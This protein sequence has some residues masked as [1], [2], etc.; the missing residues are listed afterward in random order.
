MPR[1]DLG[2]DW[3]TREMGPLPENDACG[4]IEQRGNFFKVPHLC[5]PSLMD[6]FPETCVPEIVMLVSSEDTPWE[7]EGNLSALRL[8]V[9]GKTSAK[10][11][12]AELKVRN[13][14][15]TAIAQ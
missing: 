2:R 7:N 5:D 8:A 9:F 1:N 14:V 3:L 15:A 13:Q 12:R 4:N 10:K 6:R 11:Q